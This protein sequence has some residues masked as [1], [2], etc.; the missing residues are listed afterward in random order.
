MSTSANTTGTELWEEYKVVI[1][2]CEEILTVLNDLHLPKVKPRVL[3]LTDAG[4][5]AGCNNG[6]VQYRIAD[7]THS[8]S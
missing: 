4:P 2:K 3:E 8:W 7:S 5:G 6:A 1:K